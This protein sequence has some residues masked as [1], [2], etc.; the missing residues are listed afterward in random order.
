VLLEV[1][2]VVGIAVVVV[3]VVTSVADPVNV[4]SSAI[5]VVVVVVDGVQG[6]V[7]VTITVTGTDTGLPVSTQTFDSPGGNII[8]VC[9]PVAQST[10]II[11]TGS[12]EVLFNEKP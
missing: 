1:V 5:V 6:P 8:A 9:N 7:G 10:T 4:Q 2:V 11:A 3:V 12:P